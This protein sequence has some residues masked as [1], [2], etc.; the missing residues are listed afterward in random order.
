MLI[1][2]TV[3]IISLCICISNHHIYVY[4]CIYIQYDNKYTQFYLKN[5]SKGEESYIFNY[6]LKVWCDP[7]SFMYIL[8]TL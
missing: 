8:I 2:L 5:K 1:S 4:I 7:N 6:L 3:V